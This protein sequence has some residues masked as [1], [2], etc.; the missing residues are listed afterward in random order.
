[1]KIKVCGMKFPENILDVSEL[2]PDYMGFIFWKKST[3]FFDGILPDLPK[4]ITKTGVF[5]DAPFEETQGK[6]QKYG[7]KAVQLHGKETPEFCLKLKQENVEIIKAFAIDSDFDF[8]QIHAFETVCDSFLFDTKGKF[9]GGNGSTFDW[10]ILEKYPSK[11][12]F[13]LSGGLGI[14]EINKLKLLDIPLYAIDLN[15]RF[16]SHPGLK[17]KPLLQEAF[18]LLNEKP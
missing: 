4:S 10:N 9:P 8:D 16:E 17:N 13:F 2:L 18:T 5:V 1:M 6:I 14:A 7:L 12:P 11:K 3:R 15:S